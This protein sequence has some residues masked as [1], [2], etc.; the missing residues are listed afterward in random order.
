MLILYFHIFQRGF[1]VLDAIFQA[2]VYVAIVTICIIVTTV[3]I[4]TTVRKFFDIL[5]VVELLIYIVKN[6]FSFSRIKTIHLFTNP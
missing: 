6:I 3:T 5:L 1:E 2:S 4:C